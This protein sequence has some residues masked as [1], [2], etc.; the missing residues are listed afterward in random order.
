MQTTH[1]LQRTPTRQRRRLPFRCAR[2]E[3]AGLTDETA[4]AK[5]TSRSRDRRYSQRSGYPIPRAERLRRRPTTTISDLTGAAAPVGKQASRS[6][7][8]RR[9][10]GTKCGRRQARDRLPLSVV[11]E[12]G[13]R[14]NFTGPASGEY[15]LDR[16]VR[17][18]LRRKLGIGGGLGTWFEL[19]HATEL[20]KLAGTSGR[21]RAMKW[22][23]FG[24]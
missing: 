7:P 10:L 12:S 9:L 22:P 23:A 18:Q 5:L 16:R 19:G 14:P 24:T 4:E 2:R 17:N 6:T 8:T 13:A 1:P 21:S 3:A 11:H 20:S 15:G